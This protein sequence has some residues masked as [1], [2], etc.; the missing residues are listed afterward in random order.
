MV[1]DGL[2]AVR[3]KFNYTTITDFINFLH[4]IHST[5]TNLDQF[6]DD[7]LHQRELNQFSTVL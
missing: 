3:H 2:V 4:R 6:N 1:L 5:D 7:S